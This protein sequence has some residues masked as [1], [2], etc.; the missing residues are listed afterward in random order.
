MPREP[1]IR[2]IDYS[3]DEFLAGTIGL[4]DAE[5]GLYWRLCTLIYSRGRAVSRDE[6][7][8]VSPSHGKTFN[9]I[10]QRLIEN[11][12][13][14]VLGNERDLFV[15]RCGNELENALKRVR[16]AR[17]NGLKGG[18]PR[19]ENNEIAKPNGLHAAKPNYQLS[20]KEDS[21]SPP[22]AKASVVDTALDAAAPSAP[23]IDPV[24]D[25]WDRGL[26]IIGEK[27]RSLLGQ[28]CK[29][30]GQVAVLQAIGQCEAEQPVDPV[31]FFLRCC[32]QQSA[33]RT[34]LSPGSKML[35][36]GFNAAIKFAARTEAGRDAGNADHPA[37]PLLDAKRAC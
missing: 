25:L 17:E 27:R 24:K 2:R 36:G 10:V 4:S 21:V 34:D 33:R 23:V 28:M 15:K 8:A 37:L 30:F 14:L 9:A 35:I 22:E 29:R 1:K 16:N 13:V 11:G 19:K 18:R 6:L 12:K 32:E 26:A 3:P 31:P 5:C 20:K 7:R